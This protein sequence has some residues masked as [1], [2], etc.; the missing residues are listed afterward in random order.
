MQHIAKHKRFP[1][2]IGLILTLILAVSW[3][4]VAASDSPSQDGCFDVSVVE[5]VFN[6]STTTLKFRVSETGGDGCKDLSHWIVAVNS[7]SAGPAPYEV[8]QD[9]KTGLTGTKWDVSDSFVSGEFWVTLSGDWSWG[10]VVVGVKA[11]QYVS[12]WSIPLG[13]DCDGCGGGWEDGGDD[14]GSN[15]GDPYVPPEDEYD[16]CQDSTEEGACYED[17]GGESYGGSEG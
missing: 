2:A 14:G 12:T 5:A 8:G 13:E 16:P 10:E 7:D 11:G 3:A 6:G 9:K 15:E 17:G 4:P 1:I